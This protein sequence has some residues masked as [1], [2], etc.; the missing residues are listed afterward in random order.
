MGSTV[1]GIVVGAIAAAYLAANHGE[2][3]ASTWDSAR[4]YLSGLP[5]PEIAETDAIAA[6]DQ[7]ITPEPSQTLPIS[8]DSETSEEAV[9]AST[10]QP[11]PS[12]QQR[13]ADFAASP[14]SLPTRAEFPWRHCFRRAAASY[15]LPEPLLL[16]IASGESG[17]DPAARSAADAV[18]LMQI[19]WPQ[20]GH[21]LG[22]YREADLYDPCTN[23]DAGGRYLREL[24][25]RFNDDL[26][27]AVAAYNYG[28]A[29]IAGD[30]MPEGA[31]WYSQYIYQHLQQVLGREHPASSELLHSGGPPAGGH[32]VLMRF[33]RPQRARDFIHYLQ[34]QVP[35]LDLQQQSEVLGQQ[36]VVLL[37][38]DQQ[39]RDRALAS[40]EAAGIVPLL[41]AGDRSHTL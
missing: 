1:N 27:L 13:W 19:R 20:T 3:L 12:L 23:V 25:T 14:P 21:H 40:L 34:G 26:H 32:L 10:V 15:D 11:P 33:N 29:R 22:I 7:A 5:V 37:F 2:D 9:A 24:A 36:E 16:A 30:D 18:G 41:S 31:R 8:A 17:F 4:V 28:P 6:E 39:E 35:G 38:R